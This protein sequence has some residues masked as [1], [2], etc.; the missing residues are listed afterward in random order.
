MESRFKWLEEKKMFLNFFPFSFVGA[1]AKNHLQRFNLSV[2]ETTD[3]ASFGQTDEQ[4]KKFE[5]KTA[6]NCQ[7]SEKEMKKKKH[8]HTKRR[9]VTESF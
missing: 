2:A 7:E 3:I 4:K 1:S 6:K 9:R 8:T 5:K